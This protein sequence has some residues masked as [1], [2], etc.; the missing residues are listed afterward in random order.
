MA[1]QISWMNPPSVLHLKLEGTVKQ[2]DYIEISRSLI[3]SL[4][5]GS[6][7]IAL[8][9]DI[10]NTRTIPFPNEDVRALQ[11]FA[12]HP[13]LKWIIII[14]ENKLIRLMLMLT[15]NLSKVNLSTFNTYEQ[16]ESY[17]EVLKL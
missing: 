1:H 3:D 17:L 6:E 2:Q 8:V 15:L 7:R 5:Q 10:T 4:N 13:Y 12:Y 11:T 16:V 9:I 14:G